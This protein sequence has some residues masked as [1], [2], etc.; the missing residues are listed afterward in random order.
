MPIYS[1]FAVKYPTV[2]FFA[3]SVDKPRNKNKVVQQVRSKRYA[4]NVGIDTSG[5]LTRLFSVS[6][7]PT[8]FIIDRKGEIILQKK[9]FTPGDEVATEEAIRRALGS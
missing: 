7:L 2:N 3:V 5:D 1:D 4:F 8:L 9:G 6:D